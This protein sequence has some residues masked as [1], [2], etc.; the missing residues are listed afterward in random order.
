MNAAVQADT[1]SSCLTSASLAGNISL[2]HHSR[3]GSATFDKLPLSLQALEA[4]VDKHA[5]H[6]AKV[7]FRLL[8]FKAHPYSMPKDTIVNKAA[9]KVTV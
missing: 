7:A 2:C 6:G 3:I 5:P 8:G 9:A 4:H 1:A